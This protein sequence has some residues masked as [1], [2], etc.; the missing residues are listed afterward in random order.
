MRTSRRSET[1]GIE[2]Q[3]SQ[4]SRVAFLPFPK[5]A[6]LRRSVVEVTL[7]LS[8]L[9][10]RHFFLQAQGPSMYLYLRT[11]PIS[12]LPFRPCS[13]RL[14]SLRVVCRALYFSTLQFHLEAQEKRKKNKRVCRKNGVRSIRKRWPDLVE[15]AAPPSLPYSSTTSIP[16]F[17][18]V[19]LLNVS[20]VILS[21]LPTFFTL[22]LFLPTSSSFLQLVLAAS[23]QHDLL[24]LSLD[25][26]HLPSHM[27]LPTLLHV[28]PISKYLV[29]IPL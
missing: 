23:L 28:S 26:L 7:L 18:L 25:R 6:I 27:V 5:L 24:H 12:S 17:N 15:L 8:V 9:S 10:L 3:L 1:G 29:S 11:L 4:N 2:S 16:S 13:A 21:S 20:N 22:L 19:L 14:F